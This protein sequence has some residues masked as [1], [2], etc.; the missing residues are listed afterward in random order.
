[1]SYKASIIISF[2]NKISLLKFIF[3]AL[4]RQTLMDFEVVIADDGSSK[5]VVSEL[6]SILNNYSFPIRHI[7]HEDDGWQKNRILNKAV[8][9][10]KSDYLIFIDAD[11]IPHPLF[12][13]EHIESRRQNQVVSGRSV[14]LTEKISK[15]LTLE[16]VQNGYLDMKVIFPLAFES[17][18][19]SYKTC[20]ENII[21]IRNPYLR[22]LL[23]KDKVKGFWGCNFSI[24]KV[25]ILKVNGFDERFVY[26]GFGEDIDLERR[27]ER[28]GVLSISK[29]HMVTQCHF[30][31]IHFDLLHKPNLILHAENNE[32]EVTYTPFGLNKTHVEK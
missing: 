21:R 32:N 18:S 12:V 25:N 29:K 7:W 2:Y 31:H 30:Y 27:L 10:S 19:S 28:I 17:I 20:F 22:R 14:M 23:I 6:E 1:M 16:K 4:E 3:A 9:A 13:Q 15:E 11:C 5:E 24:Y 26:P 8:I